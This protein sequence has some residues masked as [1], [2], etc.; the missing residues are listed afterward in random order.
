MLLGSLHGCPTPSCHLGLFFSHREDSDGEQHCTCNFGIR[1][2]YSRRDTP[3]R[4]RTKHNASK[5]ASCL[6][7]DH[8]FVILFLDFPCAAMVKTTSAVLVSWIAVACLCRDSVSASSPS[9]ERPRG[10]LDR[11]VF[12]SS[13]LGRDQL[14]PGARIRRLFSCMDSAWV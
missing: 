2:S 9:G 12:L 13:L 14:L 6:V 11:D 7:S 4:R 3:V 5:K 10:R 8:H 1:G